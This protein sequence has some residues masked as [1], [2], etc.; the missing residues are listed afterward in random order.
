VQG[1]VRTFQLRLE[2]LLQVEVLEV[3]ES[4][5]CVVGVGVGWRTEPRLFPLCL[6]NSCLSQRIKITLKKLSRYG[7]RR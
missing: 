5:M 1:R 7:E 6:L 4:V 3:R 2:R